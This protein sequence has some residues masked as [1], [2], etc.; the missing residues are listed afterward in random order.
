MKLDKIIKIFTLVAIVAIAS[1]FLFAQV[2][3]GLFLNKK[4]QGLSDGLVGHW[5]FDG[6]DMVSNVADVSGQGNTGYLNG[7]TATTS[8]RG[9]LGQALEFDGD[10]DYVLIGDKSS[11]E[12]LSE[13]SIEVWVKT[14]N[15]TSDGI[16][17]SKGI[18]AGATYILWQDNIAS[19]SLRTNTF[20]FAVGSGAALSRVEGSANANSVNEWTHL[21]G[22]WTENPESIKLY[23]NGTLDQ[24]NTTLS[25]V[26][27]VSDT[28]LAIIGAYSDNSSNFNG[29]LDNAR[30]YNR[31][32]S[33]DEV[34][35]LYNAGESKFNTSKKTGLQDGLVG[36][37]TFDGPDMVSNVADVSGQGNTGY[38]NG[39]TATTSVRGK[40]G[41]ALEFDGSNDYVD[42]GLMGDFDLDLNEGSI[43]VWSKTSDTGTQAHFGTLNSP[44]SEA[45][46][47]GI[48]NFDPSTG[49]NH[50]GELQ[51]WI[52][53]NSDD[54]LSGGVNS[55]TGISDGNWHN[56]VYTWNKSNATINIYID[57]V[58]QTIQYINTSS[59]TSWVAW[60]YPLT[61]GALNFAGTPQDFFNGSMDDV[62]I[63][64]RELSPDEVS[65]LYNSSASKFNTSKKT[66]LQDGLVGHWTFDGPDMVSNVADV[67]GQGNTGYLNGQTATTSVR[68]KLGQALEF[69]GV[70]DTV[71]IYDS[72][73][74][75]ITGAVAASFWMKLDSLPG[76]TDSIYLVGKGYVD[77]Y[78]S[79]YIYNVTFKGN[80]VGGADSDLFFYIGDGSSFSNIETQ[81]NN[82]QVGTWYH[83]VSVWDGA[84]DSGGMRFYID[85]TLNNTGASSVSSIQSSN[86]DGAIGDD[87]DGTHHYFFDGTLDDV[88]IYN[89]ALSEDEIRQLYN[90]G[91]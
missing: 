90:S 14:T 57:G 13:A 78:A 40:L 43:S 16:I 2:K 10:D 47:R 77:G 48:T 19:I 37:W 91:R 83:V 64:D 33:A 35:Q 12:G 65:Q 59:G 86:L 29:A 88:R 79:E 20:S 41:Q 73:S 42:A 52:R 56:I 44:T 72:V 11:L 9:K 22:V 67:S 5:T 27:M 6:P 28:S 31:A 50:V 69:D 62:R 89:R 71:N 54:N 81:P 85:G 15:N 39:Q 82:W 87:P 51:F 21:V 26:S 53:A 76:F 74:L 84:T 70:D 55:D 38:L 17:V 46:I 66:G 63:Y 3:A 30:I 1:G 4:P 75:D 18:G 8:V 49:A 34:R 23:V 68:G 24:Q 36:H 45:F 58:S 32:L 60:D 25:S 61:L 80:G 7:Q